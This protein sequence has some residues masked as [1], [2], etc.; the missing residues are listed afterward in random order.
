VVVRI[1]LI[2]FNFNGKIF[3]LG[4]CWCCF[5]FLNDALD[6]GVSSF[7]AP[8][9]QCVRSHFHFPLFVSFDVCVPVSIWSSAKCARFC[10]RSV[11][12]R[13]LIRVVLRSCPALNFSRSSP[14]SVGLLSVRRSSSRFVVAALVFCSRDF[15]FSMPR[16][17]SGSS[18]YFL[19]CVLLD[20]I[21]PPFASV[22]DAKDLA[23]RP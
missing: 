2:I 10:C 15:D 19:I 7:G 5:F 11:L 1:I 13:F 18:Y 20:L 6:L 3:V 22:V 9:C 16:Q 4:S 12:G 14:V 17:I 21:L 8:S 23:A